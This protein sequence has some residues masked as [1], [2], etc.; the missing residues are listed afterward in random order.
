MERSEEPVAMLHNELGD[1]VNVDFGWNAIECTLVKCPSNEAINYVSYMV[2]ILHSPVPPADANR[3]WSGEI[4][5]LE[6]Q[7]VSAN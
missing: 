2:H 1:R 5:P 7:L 3:V 6:T 4:Y